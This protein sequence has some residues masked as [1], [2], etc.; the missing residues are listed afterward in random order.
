MPKSIAVAA[1]AAFLFWAGGGRGQEVFVAGP[2][3]ALAGNVLAVETAG[4]RRHVRLRLIEAPPPGALCP[5]PGGGE[6]R[7][8]D[9]SRS[10]LAGQILGER[11]ACR[12]AA[13]ESETPAAECRAQ[14]RDLGLWMLL[15]GWAALRPEARG[16]EPGYDEAEALARRLGA[17]IWAAGP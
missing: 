3:E 14:T 13:G 1:L 17:M 12:L 5:A 10:A 15:A 6:W 9:G 16:V 7:C 2:A 4:G 11:I 8:G